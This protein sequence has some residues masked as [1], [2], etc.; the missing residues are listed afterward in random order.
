M[1]KVCDDKSLNITQSHFEKPDKPLTIEIDCN[2]Y[3]QQQTSPTDP[4]GDGGGK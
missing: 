2:K 4:F 3:K 1:Q